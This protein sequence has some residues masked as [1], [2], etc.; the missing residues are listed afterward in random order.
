MVAWRHQTRFI[1]PACRFAKTSR[2]RHL[3][4]FYQDYNVLP[5]TLKRDETYI[6]EVYPKHDISTGRSPGRQDAG[7]EALLYRHMLSQSHT[8]RHQDNK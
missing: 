5:K 1:L 6:D 8:C 7:T 4:F 2:I 3:D